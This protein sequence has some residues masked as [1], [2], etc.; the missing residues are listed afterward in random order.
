MMIFLHDM[1]DIALDILVIE[2]CL[3]GSPTHTRDI[4]QL[5]LQFKVLSSAITT[6]SIFLFIFTF[7]LVDSDI[8]GGHLTC[9]NGL[10]FSGN[11][12]GC[13][14]QQLLPLFPEK[15]KV[16]REKPM[17]CDRSVIRGARERANDT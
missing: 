11:G 4:V 17:P 14:R 7:L 3:S 6:S 5:V 10:N 15:V 9:R 13:G 16:V 1:H 12:V 8:L 2:T